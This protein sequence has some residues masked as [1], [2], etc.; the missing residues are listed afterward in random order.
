MT[1]GTPGKALC[2]VLCGR[3]AGQRCASRR[4]RAIDACHPHTTYQTRLTLTV[5]ARSHGASHRQPGG[6]DRHCVSWAST[7]RLV[8]GPVLV[9]D[10]QCERML[11]ARMIR[12]ATMDNCGR[13]RQRQAEA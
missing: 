1:E 10:P 7:M 13:V 4:V 3:F 12:G 11:T 2:V 5:S 9:E 6:C 8:A